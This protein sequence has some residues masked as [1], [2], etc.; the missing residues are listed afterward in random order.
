MQILNSSTLLKMNSY[1]NFPIL[2]AE[3]IN[4]GGN[5]KSA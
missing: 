4:V 2:I 3:L 1:Q 5:I